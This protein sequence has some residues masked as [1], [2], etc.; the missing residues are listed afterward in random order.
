MID[1]PELYSDFFWWLKQGMFDVELANIPTMM[2][3]NL[4]DRVI[5]DAVEFINTY[6][7]IVF[8]DTDV[9]ES[10]TVGTW[11]SP[12]R[13][14]RFAV[15]RPGSDIPLYKKYRPP[16]PDRPLLFKKFYN[17]EPGTQGVGW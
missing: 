7:D 8:E 13:S 4:E 14:K 10:W 1:A 5:D 9:T 15:Y 12:S 11:E 6:Y 2:D 3:E 16:L 17:V